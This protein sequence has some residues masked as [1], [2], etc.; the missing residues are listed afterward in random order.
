MITFPFS[1]PPPKFDMFV[2]YVYMYA[3]IYPTIKNSLMGDIHQCWKYN[4]VEKEICCWCRL[5]PYVSQVLGAEELT[6]FSIRTN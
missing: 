2:W 1:Y 4:S 3:C 6:K 5:P